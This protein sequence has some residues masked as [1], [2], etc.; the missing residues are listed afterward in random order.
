MGFW[1]ILETLVGHSQE[2]GTIK[3]SVEAIFTEAEEKDETIKE[4][5]TDAA[6]SIAIDMLMAAQFGDACAVAVRGK[7]DIEAAIESIERGEFTA[8]TKDAFE[9]ATQQGFSAVAAKAIA[10]TGTVLVMVAAKGGPDPKRGHHVINNGLR[11]VFGKM[12]GDFV[13]KNFGYFQ[14]IKS[15]TMLI[16]KAKMTNQTIIS[17]SKF[18]PFGEPYDDFIETTAVYTPKGKTHDDP[19]EEEYGKCMATFR[20]AT[21]TYMTALFLGLTGEEITPNKLYDYADAKGKAAGKVVVKINKED[22]Y[23]DQQALGWWLDEHKTGKSKQEAKKMFEKAHEAVAEM[24]S[25]FGYTPQSL[26]IT[27]VVEFYNAYKKLN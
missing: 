10:A 24:F 17:M 6:V 27:M 26:G 16:D 14:G 11:K 19:N 22:V 1:E 13:E 3:E 23:V 9:A 7:A 4:L 20:A 25:N 5:A 21:C 18:K 15:L 2:A 8:A 12:L